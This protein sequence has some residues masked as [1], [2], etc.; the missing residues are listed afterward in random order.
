MQAIRCM[1]Y[2]CYK[3]PIAKNLCMSHYSSFNKQ[4]KICPI[5]LLE[6]VEQINNK[7]KYIAEN[8]DKKTCL[9]KDCENKPR[10]RHLCSSHYRH[11]LNNKQPLSLEEFV[12]L[13]NKK[14]IIEDNKNKPS[15]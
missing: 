12:E 6:Y 1:I 8:W 13:K 2:D 11:Y 10:S 5:E 15:I 9:I 7:K 3:K 14:V 4:R